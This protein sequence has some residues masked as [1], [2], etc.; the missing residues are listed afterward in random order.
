MYLLGFPKPGHIYWNQETLAAVEKRYGPLGFDITPYKKNW[1]I[2]LF[3]NNY[4]IS[5]T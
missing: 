3:F 1:K 5:M 4:I 2:L